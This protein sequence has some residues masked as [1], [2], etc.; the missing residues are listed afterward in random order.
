[1]ANGDRRLVHL[2]R[3]YSIL[4][5][6]ERTLGRPRHL[7][8]SNRDMD[9]PTRGVYFF[10]EAGERRSDS[11]KGLRVV[12]VGTVRNGTLWKRLY[13]HSI[14]RSVFGGLVMKALAESGW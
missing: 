4:R 6:L 3:F 7:A 12:R 14:G 1:M 13:A 8:V 9:W 5:R 11:G 2:R 10:T